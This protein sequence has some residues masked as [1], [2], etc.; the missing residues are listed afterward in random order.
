MINRNKGSIITLHSHPNNNPPTGSDL[1]SALR[2]GYKKGYVVTIAGDVHEYELLKKNKEAL[3][4]FKRFDNK[5]A[6]KM[7]LS[8][9]QN[10][11][12]AIK[13]VLEELFRFVL[14]REMK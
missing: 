9:N 5:V 14:W 3:F 11:V 1:L 6:R 2:H 7:N 4:V 8:Y 13:S 10:E 12:G